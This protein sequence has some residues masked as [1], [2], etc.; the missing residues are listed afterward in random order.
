[1]VGRLSIKPLVFGV[2]GGNGDVDDAEV[3][4]GT[5]AATGFDHDRGEGFER[6]FFAVEFNMAFSFEDEVDLGHLFMVVDFAVFLDVDEV[7]GGRG[8]FRNGKCPAGLPTWAWSWVYFIELGDEVVGGSCGFHEWLFGSVD[9]F[10]NG[11]EV[12]G[13][14]DLGVFV[15]DF[16]V[17]ADDEGPAGWGVVTY[18]SDFLA[19]Y[20]T[21]EFAAFTGWDSKGFGDVSGFIRKERKVQVFSNFEILEGFDMITAYR[22]HDGVQLFE[23]LCPVTIRAGLLGAAAGHGC[24]VEVDNHVLFTYVVFGFP[25]FA[26][27]ILCGKDRCVVSD[28]N[29]GEAGGEDDSKTGEEELD[30]FHKCL[31]NEV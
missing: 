25:D 29:G 2:E 10:G 16:A 8:V 15:N 6:V 28:F 24:G 27:V 22:D 4:D 18:Q 23:I 11:F 3:A 5:M 7:D 17:F 14:V 19:L 9:G 21:Y 1:M 13:R 31:G 20:F 26:G 30:G 12:F